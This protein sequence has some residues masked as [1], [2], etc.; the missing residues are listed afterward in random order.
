VSPQI[1]LTDGTTSAL[2]QALGTA[3]YVGVLARNNITQVSQPGAWC[4]GTPTCRVVE[5]CINQCG[6]T[7]LV[8]LAVAAVL[9]HTMTLIDDHGGHHL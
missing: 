2:R 4:T 1:I 6:I 7:G 5:A 3:A 8:V 9:E